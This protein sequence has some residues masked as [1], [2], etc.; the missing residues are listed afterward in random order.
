ML[1]SA[2]EE[3]RK[4]D[5]R[6][7]V[8]DDLPFGKRTADR[9]MSIATDDRLRSE[10]HASHLPACWMT[11]YELH[12]LTDEQFELGIR[13][14]AIY[15][16]MQRKNVKALRG[17]AQVSVEPR[18][19]PMALLKRQ[20]DERIHEIARLQ[21]QLTCADQGSLFDLR[22]DTVSNIANVVVNTITE[23]KAIA[24]ADA[25]KAAIKAKRQAR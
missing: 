24:L 2:K 4:A 7:M 1:D 15:P 16:K 19:S 8:D 14:G 3:L 11:L 18:L 5:W 12:R 23:S 22:T 10:T 21:A 6:A 13:T 20:L 9:L 25:I 17:D